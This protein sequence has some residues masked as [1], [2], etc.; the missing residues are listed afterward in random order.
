[1]TEWLAYCAKGRKAA[2]ALTLAL[3][4]EKVSEIS[5]HP[6]LDGDQIVLINPDALHEP[7]QMPWEPFPLPGFRPLD[8]WRPRLREFIEAEPEPPWLGLVRGA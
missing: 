2:A 6:W 7:P 8:W 3:R 1:V 5:E 4:G